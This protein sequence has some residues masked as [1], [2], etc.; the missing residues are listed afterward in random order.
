M[1]T[2][3]EKKLNLGCGEAKKEGYVNLDWQAVVDPDVL[4]DLNVFPYPFADNTF[5]LIAAFHVMEH[6]D[7]PF[8]VMKEL[9]RILKPDGRLHLKVPHFSR[10]FTHAEHTHGFDVMFPY[11]F[12]R[13]FTLSGYTGVEFQLEKIE[14]H[15]FAFP[16]LLRRIGYGWVSLAILQIMNVSFSFLANLHPPFC[17]RIWCYWVGGFDEIEFRFVATK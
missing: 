17:S 9:H 13:T 1:D 12:D 4:H 7:H 15:W 2:G 14:F 5:D 3:H 6:L 11:Y 10:G 16:H 8:I